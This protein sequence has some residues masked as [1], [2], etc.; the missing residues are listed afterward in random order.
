MALSSCQLQEK[1][2]CE[3]KSMVELSEVP[4]ASGLEH[5]G[6][7]YYVIGDNAPW[8][9]VLDRS[10]HKTSKFSLGTYSATEGGVMTKSAKHDFEAMTEMKW[11][12]DDY[13]FIKG[14]DYLLRRLRES[15]NN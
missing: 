2:K 12:G 5:I 15:M 10:F 4:S 14:V 8:V 1:M 3:V 9:F 6:D 13:L 7:D 11:N